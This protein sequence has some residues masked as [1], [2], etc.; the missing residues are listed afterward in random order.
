[1]EDIRPKNLTTTLRVTGF[2]DSGGILDIFLETLE[3]KG[4]IAS[5][6][7]GGYKRNR[8]RQKLIMKLHYLG[9]DVGSKKRCM[10]SWRMS[11]GC[12]GYSV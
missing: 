4:T 3:K 5:G 10:I 7:K 11:G 12:G 6:I 8:L 2:R 9:E 1:M